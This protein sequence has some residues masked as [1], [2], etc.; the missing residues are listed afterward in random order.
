MF[1]ILRK[2]AATG[3][4]TI[5]YPDGAAAVSPRYRGAPRFD[6]ARWL[7]ARPAAEACP[8]G[9]IAYEERDGERRVT[10]DYGLCIYCGACAEADPSVAM[11]NEFELAVRDRR[12]LVVTAEYALGRDGVQREMRRLERAEIAD[13]V[14]GRIDEVLGRSLA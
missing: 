4:V 3:L 6:F 14:R 13:A 7:D 10:V 11:S 1:Q 9:A 5:G 12:D 2:T 8:T